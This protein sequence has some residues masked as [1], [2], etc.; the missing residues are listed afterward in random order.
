MDKAEIIKLFDDYKQ[1]V[2]S[3]SQV[4]NKEESLKKISSLEEIMG[5]PDF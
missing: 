3:L 2:N 4:I 5:E 1:R